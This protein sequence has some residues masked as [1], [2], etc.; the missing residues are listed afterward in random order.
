MCTVRLRFYE[1]L[2]DFL[3]PQ[4][5][6]DKNIER[7]LNH[8]TTVKDVIESC[9]VPHT[10]VDLILVNG[11][12]KR[13]DYHIH[14]ADSISVYPVFESLDISHVTRLQ[15]RPLRDLKFAADVQL[16]KLVK[17][18]RILGLSVAY[19]NDIRDNEL[20]EVM[21]NENRVLLTRDRKLLMHKIVQRGY[22]V[23]SDSPPVQIV[24]VVKRFDLAGQ[25]VPF[26]RCTECNGELQAVAKAEVLDLLEPKTKLYYDNFVQ[27]GNCKKI[28]WKG[29]HYDKLTAWVDKIREQ[30]GSPNPC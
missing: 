27:C 5:R 15:E 19:R 13:F 3:R 29:T 22:L 9:G 25:L 7:V 12:S 1:E 24:E 26:A 17:K 4:F 2:N 11:D 20:L 10:E 30:P 14:N 16:G 28:Y 21:L 18:M 23:R 8:R 6:K